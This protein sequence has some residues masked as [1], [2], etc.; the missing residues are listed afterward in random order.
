MPDRVVWVGANGQRI[1]LTDHKAGYTVTADGTRGLSS[2]TYS[3]T[4]EEY[5]GVDGT[6][7]Q[8]I[9]AEPNEPTLG[10]HLR[11]HDERDLRTKVRGLVHAMRPQAGQG[12]LMV[13]T[14]WGEQRTLDCYCIGGLEG[15]EAPDVTSPGRWF[16]AA[17]KFYAAD[18]WWYGPERKIDVGLNNPPPFFPIFPLVLAPSQVQGEFVVDLS[19]C[20]APAYPLWKILGPGSGLVLANTTTGRS[21]EVDVALAL[22]DVLSIN[23][24][25]GFQS[26]RLADGTNVLDALTSDPALWPLIVGVNEISVQLSDATE[27]SRITGSYVPRYAGV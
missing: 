23:T 9:K 25:P 22:G 20:D 1:D 13:T 5:A 4:T 10:L 8:A 15:D 6:T 21:I 3:M 27:D 2:V 7:V 12:Q 24:R 16:K 11:A 19:D 17:L 26:V 14:A 18:P